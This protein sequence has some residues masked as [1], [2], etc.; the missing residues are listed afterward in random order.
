MGSL[1]FHRVAATLGDL[2]PAPADAF[3]AAGYKV[4][5]SA[6]GCPNGS[7]CIGIRDRFEA[8]DPLLG[9]RMME[10]WVFGPIAADQAPADAVMADPKIILEDPFCQKVAREAGKHRLYHEVDPRTVPGLETSIRAFMWQAQ[11]LVDEIHLFHALSA[12]LELR[13]GFY[14]VRGE[15]TFTAG[16]ERALN[17]L[18]ESL[19][20]WVRRIA[21]LHGYGSGMQPLAPKER[22]ALVLLLGSTAQKLFS[23]MLG[24][25]TARA[26]EI[27]QSVHAKLSSSNRADLQRRWMTD[28]PAVEPAMPMF[29][30]AHRRTGGRHAP[31]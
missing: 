1:P 14:R 20:P 11:D 7:A 28:T 26:N 27:I 13:I 5:E 31:R 8:S 23:E 10:M 15:A 6:L 19:G 4:I 29:T 12:D 24:V 2:P 3:V 30:R 18:N 17:E 21:F 22:E 9:Y 25:S 16:D